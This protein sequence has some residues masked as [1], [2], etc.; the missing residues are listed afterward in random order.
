VPFD[1]ETLF[2]A[3]RD[4]EP[5]AFAA[6]RYVVERDFTVGFEEGVRKTAKA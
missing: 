3:A 4:L 6:A 1:L 2:T 5:A